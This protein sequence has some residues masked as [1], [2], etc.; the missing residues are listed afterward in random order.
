[1]KQNPDF[2]VWYPTTLTKWETGWSDSISEAEIIAYGWCIEKA[3][4]STSNNI[5][6]LC[7]MRSWWIITEPLAESKY[8]HAI[9]LCDPVRLM[10][11]CYCHR[12]WLRWRRAT[13]DHR[14][15][16]R[17]LAPFGT[18]IIWW[19]HYPVA[20]AGTEQ[21]SAAGGGWDKTGRVTRRDVS[22]RR[23]LRKK[24]N[25]AKTPATPGDPIKFWWAGRRR[26]KTNDTVDWRRHES[27][28]CCRSNESHQR[29]NVARSTSSTRRRW[30]RRRRR[31]NRTTIMSVS[32]DNLSNAWP[33]RRSVRTAVTVS[34]QR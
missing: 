13:A 6:G 10:Q 2:F 4:P 14:C 8:E 32:V 23:D 33:R 11:S 16:R 26:P 27:T 29:D 25:T 1:M 9:G 18:E 3:Q 7:S 21:T 34:C 15:A 22:R 28:L 20:V 19:R 31:A 12:E 30:R 5:V 24:R 17:Q